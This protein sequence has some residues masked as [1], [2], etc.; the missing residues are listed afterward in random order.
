MNVLHMDPPGWFVKFLRHP[1]SPS[2]CWINFVIKYCE[3]ETLYLWF[4]QEVLIDLILNWGCDPSLHSVEVILEDDF[5]YPQRI[6]L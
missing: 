1:K 2:A 4:R 5:E 6:F 3:R